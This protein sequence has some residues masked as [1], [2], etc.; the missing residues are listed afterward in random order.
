MNPRKLLLGAFLLTLPLVTTRIR[1]ADE[2]EYFSYLRSLVF[3]RDLEFGNEY[4]YFYAKDPQGLAGFKSTFL[5]L[6]EPRTGRHL[7]FGPLGTA[8][9]WSPFYLLAHGGVLLARAAGIDV[10]ADGFAGPYVAAACYASAFYGFLGLVVVHDTLTRRAGFTAGSALFSVFGLWS[11]S[12]LLYYLT[13]APGFSHASSFFAVA[14]VVALS[15][16]AHQL[17]RPRLLDW[18][19]CGAATGLAALIREQDG[20]FLLVPAVLLV[21]R[22]WKDRAVARGL[23]AGSVMALS[24]FVVFLPQLFAYK[25]ING[26]F[27]PSTLVARKMS[28]SS[29]HFLEVLFDPAHG[30]LAWSPLAALALGGLVVL[31]WKRRTAWAVALLVA[32]LAQAWINGA[33]ESWTQA[34]AFGARRFISVLPLLAFGLATVFASPRLTA[35]PLGA[36]IVVALFTW[37]NVSLMVQFALRLMDRQGLEWPRVAINQLTEVPPRLGRTVRLFLTDRERLVKENR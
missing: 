29:P 25:A 26:T 27:G 13:V 5:D 20:L 16:R 8:F 37:W 28:Y 3:D 11:A 23:M 21:H 12:P 6:R 35:R 15:L 24:A 30:L 1:G 7:N 34:G 33:V 22:S 31:V 17:P 19:I 10:A 14:L 4:A 9:L 18:A 36:V 32:F 2:I